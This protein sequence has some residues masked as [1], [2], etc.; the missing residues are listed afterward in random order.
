ME[1]ACEISKW[2]D[3]HKKTT[4][5]SGLYNYKHQTKIVRMNQAHH[6]KFIKNATFK[7]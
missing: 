6:R 3:V 2:N 4:S 7:R 1:A 5:Y